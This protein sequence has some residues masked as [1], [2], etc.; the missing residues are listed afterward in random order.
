MTMAETASE[1]GPDK[2]IGSTLNDRYKIVRKI[3]A[4]GMGIVYEGLHM[5]IQRRVAIK[6]LHPQFSQH[7][8][9]LTRFRREAIAATTIRHPHIVEVMDMGTAPD[10]AAY[11]VLE[12]LEGRDWSDDIDATGAQPLGKVVKILRQVC[13]GLQAAHDKNIV[14]RDLK[15]ENVFLAKHGSHTDYVKIVDFGISKMLDEPEAEGGKSSHSLT[16]TGAAMGTP[17]AMAPEQMK[18]L[19]DIDHRADL[20]ALGVMFYRAITGGYPFDGETFPL[21]AVNVLTAEPRPVTDFRRDL[22][23]EIQ[24]IVT[25]LLTK[26]RTARFQSA[27]DVRAAL[28]PFENAGDTVATT[29]RK[30]FA[31][32]Q[33]M[34]P[35]GMQAAVPGTNVGASSPVRVVAAAPSSPSLASAQSS[36]ENGTPVMSSAAAVQAALQ[37]AGV[38]IPPPSNVMPAG[39]TPPGGSAT[40]STQIPGLTPAP[41]GGGMV[42]GVVLTVVLMALGGGGVLFGMRMLNGDT[43]PPTSTAPPPTTVVGSTPPPSSTTIPTTPPTGTVAIHIQ[44]SPEGAEILLDGNPLSNPVDIDLPSGAAVHSLEIRA[45]GYVTDT[46]EISAAFPQRI[47]VTLDRVHTGGS[48]HHAPPPPTTTVAAHVDPPATHVEAPPPPPTPV[49]HED[50]PPPPTTGRP[51]SDPF[52]RH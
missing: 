11:M 10:G 20:W 38:A 52:H 3:G 27:R 2:R 34:T 42:T 46:R 26:D 14:H 31:M 30:S 23:P 35:E 13:D 49:V 39:M 47:T 48:G 51:L 5:L 45:E 43:P 24:D 16:K 21:L 50:T 8:E 40:G 1:E 6:M 7:H 33:T 29:G 37:S 12:F 44:A 28:E 18:G 22:P 9:V 17:Y 41:A 36:L 15:A 25:R 19:K 32:D 4:G